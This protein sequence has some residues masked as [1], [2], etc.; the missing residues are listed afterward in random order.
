MCIRDSNS[1]DLAY[2]VRPNVGYVHIT[3]FQETTGRELSDALEH[4]GNVDGLVLDLRGN[5]GGLLSEAVAVCD[6]FLEKG[7]VIV[8][9]MCIRDRLGVVKRHDRKP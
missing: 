6:K 1:I 7:Q 9:Q 8:S 4:F 3:N 5:P 2:M